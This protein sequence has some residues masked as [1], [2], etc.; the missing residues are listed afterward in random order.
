M[1]EQ[2]ADDVF[3]LEHLKHVTHFFEF[4]SFTFYMIDANIVYGFMGACMVTTRDSSVRIR[5]HDVCCVFSQN[6]CVCRTSEDTSAENSDIYFV[7]ITHSYEYI[8]V[9]RP[10]M[11]SAKRNGFPHRA[12]HILNGESKRERE[13]QST[14]ATMMHIREMVF[15]AKR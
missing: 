13:R 2:T 11:S 5:D 3:M 7:F 10:T 12:Q 1:R 8:N 15:V 6:A 4:S 9:L 14:I